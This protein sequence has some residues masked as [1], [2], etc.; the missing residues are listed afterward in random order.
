MRRRGLLFTFLFSSSLVVFAQGCSSSS[1][2]GAGG[3]CANYVAAFRDSAKACGRFNVS[4]GRESEYLAR[5]QR[6]CEAALAA[7]GSGISP[8]V[9]DQCAAEVRAQ[10]GDDDACEEVIESV[11]GTLGDGTPCDDDTQCASGECSKDSSSQSTPRCGTCSSAVR[12]GEPCPNGGCVTGAVC[13]SGASSAESI[14]VA[15]RIGNEG[16]S[17]GAGTGGEAVRC[18][19]GFYCRYETSSAG[20]PSGTCERPVGEGSSCGESDNQFARCAPPFT[21]V[22][23]RCGRLLGA[24]QTCRDSN[25][26][27]SGLGCDPANGTCTAIVWGENGAV[28]DDNL[29]R[30]DRGFCA[31]TSGSSSETGTC[32]DYISDGQPCDETKSVEQRCDVS[33]RC[34]DGTCQFDDPSSCK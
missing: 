7:P 8:G 32:V 21:C 2:S 29:R 6:S 11:R 34:I 1:S 30:C 13:S 17:C 12:I 27:A 26:C 15:V 19:T 5:L 20:A 16:E 4:P 10:C 14:C 28:C 24:G 31:R 18:A 25:D 23:D 33:A 9:L 22:N 3:A